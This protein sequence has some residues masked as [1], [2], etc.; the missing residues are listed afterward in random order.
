VSL[1]GGSLAIP[2]KKAHEILHVLLV[3]EGNFINEQ[4]RDSISKGKK[5]NLILTQSISSYA[6][7]PYAFGSNFIEQ[8][9]LNGIP[10]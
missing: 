4:R 2:N 10:L 6:E 7:L 1:L 9:Y 3:R 8:V 5:A